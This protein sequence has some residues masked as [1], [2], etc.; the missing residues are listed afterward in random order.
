MKPDNFSEFYPPFVRNINT[1]MVKKT[2]ENENIV[3]RNMY[4][5]N[6]TTVQWLTFCTTDILTPLTCLPL[7][8]LFE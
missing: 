2:R 1:I 5:M 7:A 4:K 8:A 3:D 6:S